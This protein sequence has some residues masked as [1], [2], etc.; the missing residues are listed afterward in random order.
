[1]T[2]RIALTSV[3]LMEGHWLAYNLFGGKDL[4]VNHNFVAL[5]VFT[6]LEIGTV[7]YT[8]EEAV[9]KFRDITMYKNCFRAMQHSFPKSETYSSFKIIVETATEKAVR[10]H[11]TSDDAGEIALH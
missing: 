1:V 2:D 4:P 9:E 7:G 8:V 6:N 10:F 5:T 11:I 3:V